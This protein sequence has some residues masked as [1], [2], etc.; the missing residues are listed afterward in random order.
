MLLGWWRNVHTSA[1]RVHEMPHLSFKS[2]K[3]VVTKALI[4]TRPWESPVHT[5]SPG[6]KKMNFWQRGRWRTDQV[7]MYPL[8]LHCFVCCLLKSK[9]LEVLRPQRD[10]TG[11][12]KGEKK[13]DAGICSNPFLLTQSTQFFYRNKDKKSTLH[14]CITSTLTKLS[15]R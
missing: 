12:V 2:L 4:V 13:G 11:L 7:R 10:H 3:Y 8:F 15:C 1:K 9:C 6:Y 5:A 14:C